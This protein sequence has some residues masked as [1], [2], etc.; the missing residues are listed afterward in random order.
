[1]QVIIVVYSAPELK[2]GV[3]FCRN[4]F[5]AKTYVMNSFTSH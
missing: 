3:F 5:E 1:M 2:R 4:N